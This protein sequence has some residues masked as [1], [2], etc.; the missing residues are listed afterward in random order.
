MRA[1]LVAIAAALLLAACGGSS[2]PAAVTG[3]T[4]ATTSTT[5]P[6]PVVVTKVD[7]KLGEILADNTGLTLYTLTANTLTA[8]TVAANNVAVVCDPTCAA[9]WPPLEVPA[10]GLLPTGGIGVGV[11]GVAPGPNSTQL[12][13]SGG[14][15]LYRFSQDKAP[16]DTKGEGVKS[17]GGTWHV[18][19][20]GAGATST[21]S[22]STTTAAPKTTAAP[23]TSADTTPDTTADTTP[24]TTPDT[25]IDP[26]ATTVT[27]AP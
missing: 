24:D 7:P 1:I 25:T 21:T 22:S 13:T 14:L 18:V 6:T 16:A 4:A 15:P 27:S 10:G 3:T 9:V 11:L 5:I 26:T 17:F 23:D 8:N 2:K 19:K 12:V 20:T